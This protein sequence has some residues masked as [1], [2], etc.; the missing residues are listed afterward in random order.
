MSF[1]LRELEAQKNPTTKEPARM[2]ELMHTTGII[3]LFRS[4]CLV[5]FREVGVGHTGK[6]NH[7]PQRP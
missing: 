1:L 2:K 3:T 7:G 5:C 6:C 4:V